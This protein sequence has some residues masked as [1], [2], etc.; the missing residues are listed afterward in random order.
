MPERSVERELC[1][2]SEYNLQASIRQRAF[3]IA[4]VLMK[5]PEL[6][7]GVIAEMTFSSSAL[8]MI[9]VVQP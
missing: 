5:T 8:R 6:A 9:K 7:K 1:S 4:S 3:Q 2:V